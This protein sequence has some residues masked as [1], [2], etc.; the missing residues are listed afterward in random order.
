MNYKIIAFLLFFYWQ[1][2]AQEKTTQKE[3]KI[4]VNAKTKTIYILGGI[5]SS[6]T[7]EDLAFSKKYNIQY[8]DFGCVAPSNFEKYEKANAQVFE[9]LTANFGKQWENE[10]KNSA[11]GFLE[12]KKRK[13]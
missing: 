12:W 5:A 13:K 9:N 3:I 8:Y 6:I 10:I 7:K 11:M 2:F 4:E 1:T